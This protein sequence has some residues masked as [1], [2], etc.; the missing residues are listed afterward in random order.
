MRL[1]TAFPKVAASL[2]RPGGAYNAAGRWVP[3]SVDPVPIKIVKPQP[4]RGSELQ[5]LPEGERVYTHLKTWTETVL[6]VGDL[7]T[8]KGV[9]YRVVLVPDYQDDGEFCKALMRENQQ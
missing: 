7:L 9:E 8:Y 2:V 6:N 5:N 3:A 4:A 1:L